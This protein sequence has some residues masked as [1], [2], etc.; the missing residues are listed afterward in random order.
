MPYHTDTAGNTHFEGTDN[1]GDDPTQSNARELSPALKQFFS[2]APDDDYN[3]MTAQPY[4]QRVVQAFRMIVQYEVRMSLAVNNTYN[5]ARHSPTPAQISALFNPSTAEIDQARATVNACAVAM[6]KIVRAWFDALHHIHND[7][8]VSNKATRLIRS[9]YDNAALPLQRESIRMRENSSSYSFDH[10]VGG[11]IK[12]IMIDVMRGAFVAAGKHI[13]MGMLIAVLQAKYGA[14]TAHT[15]STT[16][17]NLRHLRRVISD[18]LEFDDDDFVRDLLRDQYSFVECM[19]CGDWEYNDYTNRTYDDEYICRSCT[20]SRYVWSNYSE[21]YIHI[22]YATRVLDRHGETDHIHNDDCDSGDFV[23]D[24]NEDIYVHEA[25]A[26]PSRTMR[27][28]H[29]AKSSEAYRFVHSDWSTRNNRFFGIEL[30]VECRKGNP[31]EHA[32]KLN[33]ALNNGKLG[34]RCFFEEDGSL[35]HGFE[36]ITQPMGLDSHY[37]FWE[38]LTDKNLTRDLRS[39]DTSTCGLHIHI[40]RDNI[41]DLQIN[42]MCVFV[43]SPDNRNLVKAIARRYAV[44]YASIHDKKLGTAHHASRGDAR[45][46]AV[47]ITNHRTIEMRMFKGTL[48]HESMLAAIEFTNALVH[49][50]APASPAGFMLNAHRFIDYINS[51]EIKVDTRNLRKYLT[52]VGYT[53]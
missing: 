27:R 28:Y 33:D 53:A 31:G 36:I 26:P 41:K 45:Y 14:L 12:T 20:D 49:F 6:T 39:H 51:N 13:Y 40:N 32:D 1:L 37:Q 38:W 7:Y 29:T 22:E 47:N 46:E 35:S 4:W 50:T 15:L 19:D 30:E 18:V 17:S 25:Y 44:G 48:K 42:K 43:H 21:C 34:E 52:S 5:D 23:W 16:S 3:Y 10:I 8:E 24:D 9:F 2:P 11:M